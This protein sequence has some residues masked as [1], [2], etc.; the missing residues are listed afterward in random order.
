MKTLLGVAAVLFALACLMMSCS[1]DK[2]TTPEKIEG[3]SLPWECS[4]RGKGT[5]TVLGIT[6]DYDAVVKG[7]GQTQ[8]EAQRNL[9]RI[10]EG[11]QNCL[12]TNESCRATG[13]KP[14]ND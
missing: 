1:G 4:A 11:C 9:D 5:I 7:G 2:S 13:V 6:A 14:T 10:K 8:E 12:W 3:P